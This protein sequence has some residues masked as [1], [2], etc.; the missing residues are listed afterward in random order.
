MDQ[1]FV[2]FVN[3]APHTARF[4]LHGFTILPNGLLPH[5]WNPV[6]GI[7]SFFQNSIHERSG[8]EAVHLLFPIRE[9]LFLLVFLISIGISEIYP[10]YMHLLPE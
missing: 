4:S 6:F 2:S 10:I 9:S 7:I 3:Y 1:R 5:L 8:F